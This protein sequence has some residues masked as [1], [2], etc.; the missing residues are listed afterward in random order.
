MTEPTNESR[1]E[2]IRPALELMD[3]PEN[4]VRDLLANIMHF[5]R[6]EGTHD[7][8]TELE[9]AQGHF[10]AEVDEEEAENDD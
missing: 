8:E 5:C 7:F 6:I 9:A 4:A 10:W 2:R 1:A 3:E